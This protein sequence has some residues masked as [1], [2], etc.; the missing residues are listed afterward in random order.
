MKNEWEKI[1][2]SKSKRHKNEWPNEELVGFINR[3]YFLKKKNLI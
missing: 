2:S 1:Y 3:T